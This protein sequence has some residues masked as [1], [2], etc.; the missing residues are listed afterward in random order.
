MKQKTI[1]A[2]IIKVKLKR[3]SNVRQEKKINGFKQNKKI[4]V[5]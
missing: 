1:K 4:Q 3:L 5:N 2:K